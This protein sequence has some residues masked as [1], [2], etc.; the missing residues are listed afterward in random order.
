MRACIIL[1]NKQGIIKYSKNWIIKYQVSGYLSSFYVRKVTQAKL[2]V[3]NVVSGAF[4]AFRRDV[5]QN[6]GGYRDTLGEDM[7]ITS[8]FRSISTKEK[9]EKK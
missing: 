9:R 2:N 5:L 8:V 7:E 6:I 1:I 3:L 4:G